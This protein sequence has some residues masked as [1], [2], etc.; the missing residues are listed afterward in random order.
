MK[1]TKHHIHKTALFSF[2]L[3]TLLFTQCKSTNEETTQ[4]ADSLKGKNVLFVYGGYQGHDPVGCKDLFVPWLEEEGANVI[5]S[6]SLNVYANKEVMAKIDLIIQT[7]TMGS[8]S[9]APEAGLLEAIRNGVGI[10]G[11][12]GGLGDSFRNN[13]EYL[14][15]VGGQWVA[16]PGNKI[17]YTVKVIDKKDPVTRGINEFKMNTEQYYMVVDPNVKVLA[18][19]ECEGIGAPWIK[20]CVMPVAWKKIYGKGRVFYSSLCHDSG[21][22]KSVPEAFEIMKR[23]IRWAAQSKNQPTENLVH[24]IYK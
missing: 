11:W 1:T 19:T 13:P 21:D 2:L 14:F 20:G 5:L 23:G 6:D 4:N 15:M 7:W 18:T 24:P 16:H 8:I 17:E 22:F 12:H 9:G 10:A 3:L